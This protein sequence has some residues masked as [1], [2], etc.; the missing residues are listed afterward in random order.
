VSSQ[1]FERLGKR[2]YI[3]EAS[4]LLHTFFV[5]IETILPV[6]P[7]AYVEKGA[8]DLVYRKHFLSNNILG[9]GGSGT[10]SPLH[11]AALTTKKTESPQRIHSEIPFRTH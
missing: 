6:I 5:S 3:S 10:M 4:V 11:V 2:T 9:D 8:A 1:R 7:S